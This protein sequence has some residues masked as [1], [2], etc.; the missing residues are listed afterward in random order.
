MPLQR[1]QEV[2]PCFAEDIFAAID[3]RQVVAARRSE[4]GTGFDQVSVQLQQ[5]RTHLGT[6]G[7]GP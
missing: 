1:W 4:G 5:M 7:S 6:G 3:P 2:H